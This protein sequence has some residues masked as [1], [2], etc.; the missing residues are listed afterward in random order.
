MKFAVT[1]EN[2]QVFQHFGR[3][4]QFK[5][6][7]VEGDKVESS[8]LD[9]G[10]YSH[11]SLAVLL[12]DNGVTTLICGGIGDGARNM[13]NGNGIDVYTGNSGD[14]DEV[15]S[16]FIAGTLKKSGKSTC[17]DHHDCHCF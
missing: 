1:Y 5:I 14:V 3:T 12:A 11:G 15:A 4:R 9:A 2:G 16:A 6:Y 10:E 17:Q 8:V 7:E 13:L